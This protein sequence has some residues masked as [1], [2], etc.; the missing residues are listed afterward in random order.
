[1]KDDRGPAAFDTALASVTGTFSW[2]PRGVFSTRAKRVVC[3]GGTWACEW[4][5]GGS[6]ES[7]RD[8]RQSRLTSEEH[9]HPDF[10]ITVLCL[11][12]LKNRQNWRQHFSNSKHLFFLLKYS[13][14]YFK[15]SAKSHISLNAHFKFLC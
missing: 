10:Q 14:M 13:K 11:V 4:P 12:T 15:Y 2:I 7:S 6:L 5:A 1:M 9:I 8:G 3:P